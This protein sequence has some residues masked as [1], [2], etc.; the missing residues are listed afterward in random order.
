[1]VVLYENDAF[2]IL[3]LSTRKQYSSFLEKV[4]FLRKFVSKLKYWKCSEFLL[5]VK[6]KHA[7]LSN[8][9]QFWKSLV[10]LLEEPM[11]FLLALKWNL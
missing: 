7:D 9:E 6:Q 3:V 4:S 8:G 1:M 11:P 10:P 2:S 5:I